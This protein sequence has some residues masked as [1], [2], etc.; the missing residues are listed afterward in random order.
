[1]TALYIKPTHA[2]FQDLTGWQFGRL[3][4]EE[5]FSRNN[6]ITYWKCR[7]ECGAAIVV[8]SGNLKQGKSKSCGCL[9]QEITSSRFTKHG[10]TVGGKPAEYIAWKC[11]TQRCRDINNKSYHRYGGRGIT[12]CDRWLN[13]FENFYADMGGRPTDK[14]SIERID[15]E[16]NYTPDNCKWATKK[17]QNRNTATN[18]RLTYRGEM[19]TVSEWTEKLGLG[20]GTI[21][22]RIDRY[23]W[24]IEKALTPKGIIL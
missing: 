16:K 8:R 9:R 20:R 24:P 15:N 7:C 19:L 13:S 6:N 12:V 14:H 4:V 10:Y 3:A 21:C 5:F 23:G 22:A 11:M 18:R 2:R 17:E 1:M